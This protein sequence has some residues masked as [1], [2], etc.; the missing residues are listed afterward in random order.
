MSTPNRRPTSEKTL[1]GNQVKSE[2]VEGPRKVVVVSDCKDLG[3]PR[4][5]ENKWNTGFN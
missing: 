3:S 4:L 2:W 5:V 1:L